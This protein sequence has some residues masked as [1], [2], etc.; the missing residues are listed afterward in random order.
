MKSRH[1]AGIPGHDPLDRGFCQRS[2]AGRRGRQTG[3]SRT[4]TTSFPT[5]ARSLTSRWP[6]GDLHHGTSAR[7]QRSSP[8][9]R[10]R[11]PQR[12]Q[13]EY[14]RALRVS[15]RMA[16]RV[17]ASVFSGSPSRPIRRG[18][19]GRFLKE[20]R[21]GARGH[22]ERLEKGR[23]QADPRSPAKRGRPWPANVPGR[24]VRQGL[25]LNSWL[26]SSRRP[27]QKRDLDRGRTLR[28]P[29]PVLAAIDSTRGQERRPEPDRRRR[30]VQRPRPA[31]AIV[32]QQCDQRPVRGSDIAT[33][34]KVVTGILNLHGDNNFLIHRHAQ[35]PRR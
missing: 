29:T 2:A 12:E 35:P 1:Y 10:P 13:S 26:P 30:Q 15:R 34:G 9:S 3:A 16:P 4:S 18:P 32:A 25:T 14:A 24:R 11:H 8:C 22:L 17:A 20:I 19:A 28:P 23:T 6:T 7:R 33:P 31:R 5:R 21:D 27:K